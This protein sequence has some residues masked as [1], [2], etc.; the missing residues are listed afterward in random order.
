MVVQERESEALDVWLGEQTSI[1]SCALVRTEVVRAARPSGNDAVTRAHR[2]LETITLIDLD[3]ELLDSAGELE[4]PLR[5]LDAIHIA[6]AL[7]LGEALD[8]V[9]TYD[10]QMGRA[11]EAFG[12][13]V[14]APA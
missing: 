11:A 7:E 8:A 14:V 3:D 6:A 5:S 2:L 1:T 13:R 4:A 12:L 10:R 9:V